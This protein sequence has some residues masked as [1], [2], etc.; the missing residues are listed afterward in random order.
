M[1]PTDN[2]KWAVLRELALACFSKDAEVADTMRRAEELAVQQPS[3]PAAFVEKRIGE[4]LM[5]VN[6]HA[7]NIVG[8]RQ[9]EQ[10]AWTLAAAMAAYQQKEV[11]EVAEDAARK[12]AA[13]LQPQYVDIATVESTAGPFLGPYRA[14]VDL[15]AS[16]DDTAMAKAY[17]VGMVVPQEQHFEEVTA[18]DE[19]EALFSDS[20]DGDVEAPTTDE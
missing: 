2:S 18:S 20:D 17:M 19:I 15:V 4:A 12:A 8:S 1:A 11:V 5:V 7:H 10:E 6:Q 13:Q 3:D 14:A 9:A 16:A